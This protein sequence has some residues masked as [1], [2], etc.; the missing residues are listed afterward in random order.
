MLQI[1]GATSGFIAGYLVGNWSNL[2]RPILDKGGPGEEFKEELT[3][4]P[5]PELQVKE[6][7]T[8]DTMKD[9]SVSEK[10]QT[11]NKP[12]SA[13]PENII[14]ETPK[15]IIKNTLKMVFMKT[16]ASM[17]VSRTN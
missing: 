3:G 16:M 1:C 8:Y 4:G 13:S 2:N 15:G 17:F 12:S 9:K 7:M 5:G 6:D 10:G 14:E 11:E